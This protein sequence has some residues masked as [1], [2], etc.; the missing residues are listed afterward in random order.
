MYEQA[1]KILNGNDK[2]LIQRRAVLDRA[3]NL[4]KNGKIATQSLMALNV[5]RDSLVDS[6]IYRD[7]FVLDVH[8]I[9]KLVE[10]YY[11]IQEK[12]CTVS[13]IILNV[14]EEE[15]DDFEQLLVK[16]KIL[17]GL[18][19]KNDGNIYEFVPGTDEN[20][21]DIMTLNINTLSFCVPH[22]YVARKLIGRISINILDVKPTPGSV[23]QHMVFNSQE[24]MFEFCDKECDYISNL[25][26]N[27]K[28]LQY[29]KEIGFQ[30]LI[31]KVSNH[32][33]KD[34]YAYL[35][36]GN[37]NL[38]LDETIKLSDNTNFVKNSIE[39]LNSIRAKYNISEH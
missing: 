20:G 5:T 39:I 6:L 14:K 36:L 33:P 32:Y 19:I 18:P 12:P 21:Q 17:G 25:V 29:D 37:Q 24:E 4:L 22:D 15:P 27:Y 28:S 1:L 3:I 35:E 11:E 13:N 26:N 23:K 9:T 7:A 31:K 10:S 30:D 16:S 8:E 34:F 2:Y 38:S